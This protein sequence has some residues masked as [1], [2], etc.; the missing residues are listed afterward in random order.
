[1]KNRIE[2]G[3]RLGEAESS[4]PVANG[5]KAQ[6][7]DLIQSG[8]LDS[9]YKINRGCQPRCALY[10]TEDANAK[11]VILRLGNDLSLVIWIRQPIFQ[12]ADQQHITGLNNRFLPAQWDIDPTD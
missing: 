8:Y 5:L 10:L 11:L 12:F 6:A 9:A 7:A 3:Q 2:R 4:R 1:M